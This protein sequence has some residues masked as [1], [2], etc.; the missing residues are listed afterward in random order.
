[1]GRYIRPNLEQWELGFMR[2]LH[3]TQEVLFWHRLGFAFIRYHRRLNVPL[4]SDKEEA[5]LVR[6]FIVLVS[7]DSD[8]FG[9]SKADDTASKC[10]SAPDGRQEELARVVRLA[11]A[12]EVNPRWSPPDSVKDWTAGL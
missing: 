10:W 5:Q 9:P 4:R 2:D 1:V 11:D 8:S 6:D 7:G 12:D 3:V